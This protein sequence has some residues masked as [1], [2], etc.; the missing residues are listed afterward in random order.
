[1]NRKKSFKLILKLIAISSLAFSLLI[2]SYGN[3]MADELSTLQNQYAVLQQKQQQLQQQLNS[4]N[5]QVTTASQ[6]KAA[7]DENIKVTQEQ[8]SLLNNQI[9]TLNEQLNSENNNI[10]ATQQSETANMNLYKQQMCALY[11]AGSVSYIQL[12]LSSKSITDFLSRYEIL[13]AISQF[14]NNVIYNLKQEEAQLTA[15]KAKVQANLADL[16]SDEGTMAAKQALLQADDAQ[17]S[18]LVTELEQSKSSANQQYIAVGQQKNQTYAQINAIIAQ[19]A[20]E[21][22]RQLAQS[23]SGTKNVTALYVVKYAEG[24]I[25]VPYVFDC[26]DPRYGFDCSGFTQY[27]FANAAGIALTHSAA[28]QSQV[29]T[30]V[31]KGNLQ[32]GDLVFFDVNGGGYID[33]VGIYVGND[34]FIE[35]NDG[36]DSPDEVIITG[37]FSSSYWSSRYM[38]AKRLIN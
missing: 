5:Q 20:A 13:Q 23:T 37:L 24:F 12:L 3:V 28:E 9:S 8:I 32:P 21:R 1:V 2:N 11:E 14:D 15:D 27:V 10:A 25:G 34:Q 17:Q 7:L 35:A 16:Q 30:Y 18:Q 33:H 22:A 19:E 31:A 6:K 4:L 38:F 26:A 29:G 36:K